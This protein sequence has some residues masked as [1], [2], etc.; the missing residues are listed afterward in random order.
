MGHLHRAD[1]AIRMEENNGR[2]FNCAESTI[3]GIDRDSALPGFSQPCM[4]MAS[5]LG[6]GISGFGEVC[7][8]V[9]GAVLSLGLILGTDG[10]ENIEEFKEK[11]TNA[12]EIVKQYMQAFIDSWG[13]VRCRHLVEMDE[14]KLPPVGS[15]RP[16]GLPEKLC[17]EYV[18]WS[19]KKVLEIRKTLG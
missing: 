19:V 8:A 6:G 12:R 15:Q 10:S 2:S 5:I 7:G 9:S 3:I 16:L 4:R 13:S 11:R 17:E 18:D 14:G 1:W